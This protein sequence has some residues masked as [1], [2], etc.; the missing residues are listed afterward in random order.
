MHVNLDFETRNTVDIKAG[1]SKYA[2]TA[3]ILCLAYSI[4]NGEI[5]TWRPAEPYPT[6]LLDA[7]E[8]GAE[9]RA[10]NASFER[11]IWLKVMERHYDWPKVK[12]WRCTMAAALASGLPG[13]LE[14]AAKALKLDVEKD[15]AGRRLMLKMSKPCEIL[16]PLDPSNYKILLID[17]GFKQ[18][19]KLAKF[20]FQ[21]TTSQEY[22]PGYDIIITDVSSVIPKEGNTVVIWTNAGNITPASPDLAVKKDVS[23]AVIEKAMKAI[24]L[25]RNEP[26]KKM[27]WHEKESDFE[28]LLAYCAQDVRTEMA[29]DA[30]IPPLWKT[31]EG[32]YEYDATVNARGVKFDR[33]LVKACIQ[34]WD[35]YVKSLDDEL[36]QITFS[37]MK[38]S[39]VARILST[40]QSLGV[41]VGTLDKRAVSNAMGAEGISPTGRRIL[42]IRQLAAKSS[43]SKFKRILQ[44]IETDGRIR[45]CTQYH[46]A[47]TGRFA[48]R[49]IQLQNLPRGVIKSPKGQEAETIESVVDAILNSQIDALIKHGDVG[50]VL[51]SMIR[52]SIIPEV[53]KRLIAFDFSS[54]ESRGTA[55]V[56]GEE[57]LLE[58]FRK[59]ECA[60]TH[61]ASKVYGKP[62]ATIGKDS[63]ERYYGKQLVLGCIAEGTPVLTDSGWKPIESI[64][65]EDEVWDGIAF[66]K[67][68]GLLDKGTK[69][70]LNLFGSWLTPDHPVLCGEVWRESITVAQEQSFQHQ[71]LGTGVDTLRS[72]DIYLGSVGGPKHSSLNV[73][74]V[75]QSL[76]LT[77]TTSDSSGLQD[78]ISAQLRHPT[79]SNITNT[80]RQCPTQRVGSDCLTDSPQPYPGAIYP[81]VES[82]NTTVRE[83]LRYTKSGETTGQ[84]FL[85]TS[86][87]LTDG[88]I[89][90]SKWTESTTIGGTNPETSD[91]SLNPKICSIE[92]PLSRCKNESTN[93]RRRLRVYDILHCGPRNR[94]VIKTNKGPVV[95]HN[96]TY[97]LGGAGFQRYLDGYGVRLDLERCNQLVKI[98]RESNKQI[99][100]LWYALER[101]AVD[102]VQSGRP[103]KCRSITYHMKGRWLCC[104]LPSGRDIRYLDPELAPGT[105]DK[106]QIRFTGTDIS[107]RP[108][109]ESTYGG[110][111]TENVIQ[112]LC[113][114]ILVWAMARLEKAGYPVVFHVHDEAVVEVPDNFGSVEEVQRIMTEV[115]EWATGFPIGAEGFETKRYRK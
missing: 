78:V 45:G 20:G 74:A 54:V 108:I 63:E 44:C 103:Q 47:S 64:S 14:N 102:C 34:V 42:E 30:I 115:P 56:S 7:I 101:A 13:S 59:K 83:A 81:P 62:Y 77:G 21:F 99:V 9:V 29:V 85:S 22:V 49:L 90:N 113:R 98:F 106:P 80:L 3:E 50:N 111:L 39:E 89:H 25:M 86:S 51:A 19:K 60:Y 68:Q 61:M 33:P 82:T 48:G 79:E 15:M 1:A 91:S 8:N 18:A 88:T 93:L 2:E 23:K 28:K 114:D 16:I 57:W 97:Q 75:T 58:A 94:F 55:W 53:G 35:K 65:L 112:G 6:D 40:L 87:Q 69:E 95:V 36:S 84:S 31:E 105:F 43:V 66:V 4:N 96:C 10:W 104:R 71:A 67:H 107:G 11:A 17:L 73:N 37:D 32:V 92:G 24:R 110:K 52:S 109:R 70:T 38:S 100:K 5:K 76:Q 41:P 27:G 72:L 26:L 12:K 46:G